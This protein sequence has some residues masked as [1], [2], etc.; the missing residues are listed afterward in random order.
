MDIAFL[1]ALDTNSSRAANSG[2]I[3]VKL[4][5]FWNEYNVSLP[6][7]LDLAV[8]SRVSDYHPAHFLPDVMDMFGP[9]MLPLYRA[10]LVRNRVLVVTRPP[11]ETACNLGMSF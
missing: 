5:Q 7:R 2:D 9:L 8:S 4:D 10:V 3:D 1:H 11:V 6:N